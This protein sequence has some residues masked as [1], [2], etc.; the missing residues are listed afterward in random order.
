LDGIPD[1]LKTKEGYLK[2][3]FVVDDVLEEEEYHY[4]NY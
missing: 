3:G 2:D 1:E 4:D